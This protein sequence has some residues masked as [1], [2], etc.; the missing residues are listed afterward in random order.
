LSLAPNKSNAAATAHKH[1]RI[2][3]TDLPL[4]INEVTWIFY[5]YGHSYEGSIAIE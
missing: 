2:K 5:R 1:N 4:L 3:L